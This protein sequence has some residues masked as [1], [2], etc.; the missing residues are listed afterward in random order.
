MPLL[1]EKRLAGVV[2]LDA[3]ISSSLSHGDDLPGRR[4]GAKTSTYLVLRYFTDEI[5]V[6]ATTG[7][8]SAA[9]CAA[10]DASS[11][12]VSSAWR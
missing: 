7:S 10:F 6:P 9:F 8:A 4:C 2:A 11:R 1:P 5:L 3:R 12:L